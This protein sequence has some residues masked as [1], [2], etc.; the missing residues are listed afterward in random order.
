MLVAHHAV[1]SS[2]ALVTAHPTRRFECPQSP[3]LI[4]GLGINLGKPGNQN[5]LEISERQVSGALPVDGSP[6]PQFHG[7]STSSIAGS[8]AARAAAV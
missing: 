3:E 8:T 7:R 4:M 5:F 2:S 1:L 6:Y